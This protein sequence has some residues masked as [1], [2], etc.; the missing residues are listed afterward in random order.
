MTIYA[1]DQVHLSITKAADILGLGQESVR[2]LP[3]DDR[4]CLDTSALSSAIEKD[5]REGCKPFC[6]IGSAGTA[7]TGA[8]DSLAAIAQIAR[9]HNLWFHIDGAYGAPGGD[10]RRSKADVCRTGSG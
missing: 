6:V 1:S 3:S 8:I 9:A 5:L 10:G 7:A 2:L 4:F